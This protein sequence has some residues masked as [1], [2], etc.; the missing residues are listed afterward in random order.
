MPAAL[1]TFLTFFLHYISKYKTNRTSRLSTRLRG[2]LLSLGI[3]FSIQITIL[4]SCAC[5]AKRD[6]HIFLR[7]RESPPPTLRPPSKRK[8]KKIVLLYKLNKE[9]DV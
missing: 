9:Y 3:L 4:V 8:L 6:I 7:T 5:G 2:S 1:S